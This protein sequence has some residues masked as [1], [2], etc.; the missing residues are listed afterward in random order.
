MGTPKRTFDVKAAW[1]FVRSGA[2]ILEDTELQHVHGL[3]S[4]YRNRPT[5]FAD[6]KSGWPSAQA[7]RKVC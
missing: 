6:V 3:M 2:L 5:D 1:R 4:R 7:C